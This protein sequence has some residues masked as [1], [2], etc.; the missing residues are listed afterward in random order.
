M[1][2]AFSNWI[3]TGAVGI[4]MLLVACSASAGDDLEHKNL[5]AECQ[6]RKIPKSPTVRSRH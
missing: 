4:A 1:R 2:R 3:A 6:S 5:V